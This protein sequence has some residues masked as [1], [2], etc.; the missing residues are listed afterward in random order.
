MA[1]D[2]TKIYKKYKGFWVGLKNDRVTVVA[3]GKTVR[4]VLSQSKKKGFPNPIL[5]RVP[6]EIVP[7]V[8]F[9]K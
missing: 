8:G 4:E 1:T 2:W 7:Y 5:F 6:E 9:L 3:S